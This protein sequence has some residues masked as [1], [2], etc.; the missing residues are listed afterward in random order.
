MIVSGV[1]GLYV[2]SQNK[3]K[4]ADVKLTGNKTRSPHDKEI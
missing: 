1:C 4:R 2:S 3:C